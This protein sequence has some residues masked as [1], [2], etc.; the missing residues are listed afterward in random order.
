MATLV[1]G[2]LGTLVGGPVGGAIGSLIGR[3][4]DRRVIGN[5]TRE[6]P[7][8]KE[9]AVSTS[10][11]G[12]PIAR[13]FGATRAAGTIVWATDLRETSETLPGGKGRPNT[14]QYSYAISLAVALSSRPIERVG[15]IWAD[16]N[17]LR[18]EA[19]DLKSGGTLRVYLGHADQDP[20][21]LLAA[22]LGPECPAHRGL[23]YAVFEGPR[24][25]RL[26]QSPSHAQLRGVRGRCRRADRGLAARAVAGSLCTA[27]PRRR[28]DRRLCP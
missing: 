28:R 17:L 3:E 20:D 18:G 4:L 12:Q 13:L 1:F 21:P 6:G 25:G 15:R 19:G 24:A 26:R 5:P 2:A 8:L 11:Y 14:T 9:L 16:G 10:S 22:A 27:R 7:R 23:A